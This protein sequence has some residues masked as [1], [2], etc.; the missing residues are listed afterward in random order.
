ME[1]SSKG[2]YKTVSSISLRHL[3]SHVQKLHTVDAFP[4]KLFQN[5]PD[6]FLYNVIPLK[7]NQNTLF[8]HSKLE[9]LE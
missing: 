5:K 8:L 9:Y 7:L 2:Q 6:L 3:F 4:P 1:L